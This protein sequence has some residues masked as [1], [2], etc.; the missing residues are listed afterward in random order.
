LDFLTATLIA[1]SELLAA[2][3]FF[4][5]QKITAFRNMPI[6]TPNFIWLNIMVRTTLQEYKFNFLIGNTPTQSFVDGLIRI[7]TVL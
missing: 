7:P 5:S 2:M 3:L 1:S 6:L 4:L